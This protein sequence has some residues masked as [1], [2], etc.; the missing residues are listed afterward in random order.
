MFI[1]PWLQSLKSRWFSKSKTVKRLGKRAAEKN[2]VP[3]TSES[4]EPRIVL[5]AFDLVTVIPN[6]GLFLND[7]A[8]MHEAPQELTLRFSPGQTIDPA[9]VSAG[10][11]VTR[12]GLDGAFGTSDDVT[13]TPGYIGVGES[14]NEIIVRFAQT[15]PDDQ[16][17]IK[18]DGTG[19]DSLRNTLGENFN[20]GVDEQFNF[21]LDLGAFVEAVVPQPVLRAQVVTINNAVQVLDGDT[22]TI[23]HGSQT[24][25][26]EFNRTG[27]IQANRT[28]VNISGAVTTTDIAI[29]L[30]NA[31]NTYS[32]LTPAFGAN[33]TQA[34][35]QVTV[36]GTAFDPVVTR[37]AS[38]PA[39]TTV[40]AGG[41]TQATDTIVVY[42]NHDTLELTS[43][44]TPG[45]Y[46]LTNSATGE[47]ILPASVTY[48]PTL[49]T[50]VLR[51]SSTL[52]TASEFNLKIGTSPEGSTTAT[53]ATATR[54]G[55]V[56]G[57]QFFATTNYIGDI[58][59]SSTALN[60]FDLY[61][62]NL[63]LNGDMQIVVDTSLGLDT[64]VRIFNS[65][66]VD[67]TGTAVANINGGSG[68][69]DA[70]LLTGQI[71]GDYYVGISSSGNAA[72]DPAAGTG[73][74]NGTGGYGSY[75]FQI[76]AS[77][78]I[79]TADNGSTN[80]SSFTN[81][82]N[83]GQLG[84]SGFTFNGAISPQTWIEMPPLAGG[85]DEPGHR[86]L[87]PGQFSGAEVGHGVGGGTDPV[88]PGAIGTI[89]YSF[90][91]TFGPYVNVMTDAQKERAREIFEIYAWYTGME[92]AE[93]QSGGIAVVTGDPRFLAP[94]LPPSSGVSIANSSIAIMNSSINWND[95]FG[96]SWMGTAFHEIGHSIG[97]GHSYDVPSTQGGAED[98][99]VSTSQTEPYFTMEADFV[100]LLRMYR[101]D[102]SDID[103][104]RFELD[105]P[106]RLAAE[107]IAERDNSRLNSNLILYREQTIG[108]QTVRTI[109]AQND[110]YYSNDS[111]LDLELEAG[112]YFIG[113]SASGNDKYDPD[114]SDSGQ[115]GTTDGAYQLKVNFKPSTVASSLVDATGRPVDG[116]YDGKS[117]GAH[118]FWFTTG[119]ITA[120]VDKT[121]T[122]VSDGSLAAPFKQIDEALNAAGF[123]GP[124]T[125]VRI[126]GNGGSDN[127]TTT[128]SNNTPYLIGLDFNGVP[129]ADS[130]GFSSTGAV[131]ANVRPGEFQIPQGVTVMVESGALLKLHSAVI[132][133]GTSDLGIDRS[134][135]AFQV[136]GTPLQ[137]VH[138]TSL[139]D[140]SQGGDS[141]GQNGLPQVADWGGIVFRGD[142]DSA[143]TGVTLNYVNHANIK[144]GGGQVEVES[145]LTSFDAIHIIDTRPTVSFNTITN[146]SR[147]PISASPNAFDDDGFSIT[148][149]N[150][151]NP[152]DRRIG[153]DVHGNTVLNNS[154]NG[155]FVRIDTEFGT[156]VTQLDLSGRFDDT[157]ITHIITE[158]LFI[159]GNAGGP[160]MAS[161]GGA[162]VDLRMSGRL[163]ID[164]GI[165]VKVGKA[166]IEATAGAANV[167]AEGT[168]ANPIRFTSLLDDQYGNGGTFDASNN[169]TS[170]PSTQNY[171]GGFVFN[172]TS[173]GSFDYVSMTY[174]GGSGI[175]NAEGSFSA[176]SPITVMQGRLRVANSDFHS[177]EGGATGSVI[178]VLGSQPVIVGNE[179]SNN[180]AAIININ[181][182]SLKDV[183]LPD[184]GRSTGYRSIGS[185]YVVDVAQ[186]TS[187]RFDD[188]LQTFPDNRGPLIRLNTYV[189]NTT[190]GME[191]RGEY[192]TV[193]G[194]WDDTDI[195]HIVRSEITVPEHHTYSGL[196]LQS[197]D[198]GSLVVK[199]AGANA[200]FSA[201]G[202]PLDIDDR[203]GGSIY[204]LGRPG[205]PVVMTSLHDDT[206]GAGFMPNGFP[207]LDTNGNGSATTPTPG[208][209][210]SIQLRQYSNDRN[211]ATVLEQEPA[212]TH[213]NDVNNTSLR[214]QFLGTLAPNENSGDENRRLGFEVHGEISRDASSD[215]DVYSFSATVGTE[216]W[217]DIDQ[218]TYALD[219]MVELLN[220]SGVVLARA[221]N[222]VTGDTA[223]TSLIEYP[224]NKFDWLGG[225]FYTSNY[226]DAGM[227]V[228][229]PG[230]A[231]QTGTYY[232]RVRS[233]PV[234]GEEA[235]P[236]AV[237]QGLTAGAYQMQIRLRQVDEKPGS[238]VRNTDLRY[239]SNA[240]EVIGMPAHS[241]LLGEAGESSADNN[242]FGGAQPIG[243]L[244][245]SDRNTISVSGTLSGANDVDFYSFTLD[246]EQ[247]QVIGGLSDG[248]KSWATVFDIDY[249]DG[250]G[251]ADTVMAV[252]NAQGQL[253]WIGRDSDVED[254]QA[255]P[256]Q[257]NDY[258]DLLRGSVGK[259]DA[260]IGSVQLTAGAGMTSADSA[261]NVQTP[262]GS[263]TTYYVAVASNGR[264][265]TVLNATF[266]SAATAPLVRLEPVNSV[267]RI[268]EDHIGFT[269][270]N[271]NGADIAPDTAGPLIDIGTSISLSTHIRPFTL[272]DVALYV[273]TYNTLN[274]V[275]PYRGSY[276][277]LVSNLA[278]GYGDLDM[279][280]DGRLWGYRSNINGGATEGFITELD[281][282]MGTIQG[283]L[284]DNIPVP[285]PDAP[286]V[287]QNQSN[288][289]DA[290]A[291][292][293]TD[294]AQFAGDNALYLSVRDDGSGES[295]LYRA[296]DNGDASAADNTPYGYM[297]NITGG[298][299]TGATTGMQFVNGVLYGVSTGGQFFT[300]NTGNGA[301]TLIADLS[302][303]VTNFAGLTDA[304]QN[305]EGG[306]YANFLFAINSSGRMV[307]IDPTTGALQ[308]I[309]DNNRDGTV[310][311]NFLNTSIGGVT[312]LAF[313]PIDFNLW[314]PTMQRSGDQGHGVN[315]APDGTRSNFDVNING[316]DSSQASGGASM[317]F[318]LEEWVDNPIGNYF[319]YEGVNGTANGQYGVQGALGGT[320][321][322]INTQRELTASALAIGNNVN[323]PGGAY[324][325][326]TTNSFSL[327][328]FRD[329][330]KPTLYFNYLLGTQ[331]ANSNSD[332]M[333]DSARVFVSADNGV[334][335]SLVATN[336]SVLSSTSSED[337]EL[338]SFLSTSTTADT[339]AS[340]QRVQELFDN[341]ATWRQARIDLADFVGEAS[342]M[343]R[344]DYSTSGVSGDRNSAEYSATEGDQYGNTQTDNSGRARNNNVL[345]F[346]VDDIIVG[347]AERGEMVT[348]PLG[349]ASTES[350]FFGVPQN[351]DSSDPAEQ[352]SGRYQLEI[353]RGEQYSA[354]PS[355]TE[356]GQTIGTTFDTN[357]R[358]VAGQ[359]IFLGE[360]MTDGDLITIDS[361]FR[362]ITFEFDLNNS[363]NGGLNADTAGAY[364]RVN[365]QGLTTVGQRATALAAA[366]NA[367]A[368]AT[369]Q[370]FRVQAIPYSPGTNSP[371]V[372]LVNAASVT[373]TVSPTAITQ[374]YVDENNDGPGISIPFV[375]N[376]P[377]FNSGINT[378][379][380][381]LFQLFGAIGSS[382]ADVP[383]YPDQDVDFIQFTMT[384]GERIIVDLEVLGLLPGSPLDV[385]PA[386]VLALIRDDGG[387]S[388][389]FEVFSFG[390]GITSFPSIDYFA[391]V[392]GTY[393][394]A[395]LGDDGDLL[396]PPIN[397]DISF[398][399]SPIPLATMGNAQ[400]DYVLNIIA[401]DPPTILEVENYARRGD[402]NLQRQQGQVIIESNLIRDSAQYGIQV[403][404]GD[405]TVG[406]D[407]AHPGSPRF[408]ASVSSQFFVTGVY[409]TNNV[410]ANSGTGGILLAG[411]STAGGIDPAAQ[412]FYKVINNTIYGGANPSGIGINITGNAAPTLLN[413]IIANTAVGIQ[414][415]TGNTVVGHTLFSNVANPG[416]LG[417]N[418]TRINTPG[419]AT[420]PLFVNPAVYNFYLAQGS[421][422][423]DV[424]L[425]TL[426]DRSSYTTHTNP[427]GIPLSPLFAPNYDLYGQL[428]VADQTPGGPGGGGGSNPFKDLGGVERA[429]FAGGVAR[430][431]N[432]EDN[433]GNGLDYDPTLTL[434]H[435]DYNDA[436]L[437]QFVVELVD[438]GIGIDDTTV[439]SSGFTLRQRT[440]N[441]AGY[442]D[443]VDGEDYLWTY[444][445]N[446]NQVFFTSVSTFPLDARYEIVV[447]RQSIL[448]F[449]G[450]V[451]QAN[452]PTGSA[453][454]L[455]F[456][457]VVTDGAN[458]AP[459]LTA[460]TAAV[461]NEDVDLVFSV[462]NGNAI[463]VADPDAFLGNDRLRVM[464]SAS[465]GTINIPSGPLAALTIHNGANGSGLIVVSGTIAE[466]NAALNGL[467]FRNDLDEPVLPPSELV[468]LQVAVSDDDDGDGDGNYGPPP[469]PAASAI[470]M[471]AITVNA[472]NDAPTLNALSN[473]IVDEDSG[474]VPTINLAG[475]TAGG[476]ETQNLTVTA[477]SN[478]SALIPGITVGYTPNGTTGT[479]DFTPAPNQ[480]G[481]ATVTVTVRDAGFD[482][483]AGNGDDGIFTRT[484]TVTVNPVN[485]APTITAPVTQTVNEDAGVQQLLLDNVTA[486]P[487]ESQTLTFT[488]VSNMPGLIP[489]P[490]VAYTQGNPTALLSYTPV[491]NQFGTA[492]ITL[493]VTD[494]GTGLN[495]TVYTFD[496]VVN[497]VNDAPTLAAFGTAAYTIDEDA[498]ATVV[499]LSGIGVGPA[500]ESSQNIV[501]V[502]A[503][504]NN[505]TLFPNAG[506]L[507]N[508][509]PNNSTGTLTFQ[510]AANIYG[511]ATITVTV[512]DDGGT[513]NGGVN[514]F[515]RT[516]TVTVNP[517]NDPP[518]IDPI[519]NQIINEDAGLTNLGLTGIAAGP[520]GESAQTVLI[521]A[522]SDNQTLIPN[523]TI[524]YTAGNTTGTLTYTPVANRSGVA[525]ITVTL[526][527]NGGGVN[528]IWQEVFTITV[529]ALNDAPTL[530][531]IPSPAP[532]LED[533]ALQTINLSGITAGPLETQGLTITATSD[534]PGLIPN[535]TVNY[536]SPNGTG[537]LTYTPVANQSGTA[538]ITVRV[539]DSG[540]HDGTTNFNFIERTFV[541]TVTAVN[542]APTLDPIGDLSIP[543]DSALQTINLSGISAG[544]LETQNLTVTASSNRPDLTGLISV[545]Y[546]PNDPTGSLSFTP[547]GNA[548]GTATITV[549]VTD[550]GGIANGGVN[551]FSRTFTVELTPVEDAP[552]DLNLN[553]T[554]VN[555]NRPVGSVVGIF[556]PTDLDPVD[557][558]T[559]TLVAGFGDNDNASFQIVN[560]ELR[561]N[562]IFDF[563]TKSVYTI[564][565]RVT[566]SFNLWTEK[567]FTITIN[568]VNDAPTLDPLSNLNLAEDALLQTV[569][570]FGITDG[571]DTAVQNLSVTATSSHP[572]I[573]PHP[574]VNY[575]PNGT[576]GSI[577]FT[578][579]GNANG[580]VTIT[581]T[582]TDN[583][584]TANGGLNTFSRTFTVNISP[585]HDAPTDISLAP[586]TVLE[587]SPSG[588]L[589]GQLTSTDPDFGNTFAYSLVS[590]LG[591]TDNSKFQIINDQ[592][593]ATGAIDFEGQPTYS[594]RVRTLDNG[595]LSYEKVLTVNALDVNEP[596]TNIVLTPN[597]VNE[598]SPINTVVGTLS[599]IDPDV[600]DSQTYA[601]VSGAGATDNALFAL[602]GNTIRT[603]AVFDR[604]VKSSY[605]IRILATD[606]QGHTIERALTITIGNVNETPTDI[607]LSNNMVAENSAVG[608]V[609]GNLSTS[610]IDSGDSFT[611]TLVSGLGS[612]DNG[613]F[614]IVGGQLQ[615]AGNI[616][617]EAKSLLSVRVRSMDVGGL[618]VEK[619]FSIGVVNINETPT[620]LTLTNNVVDENRPAN[621]FVGNLNVSDEDA[622][623]TFTYQLVGGIGSDDNASFLL[624][625]NQLR[626][627][628]VFDF[629][630][631]SS[632]TIRVRVTDSAS[633]S[634]EQVFTITINNTNDP[635]VVVL[636][637]ASGST[638]GKKPVQVDPL[639]NF[640][641]TDS[642][643]LAGGKLIVKIAQ[644]EQTG[645]ELTVQKDKHDDSGLVL[646][647]AKGKSVL[648]LGKLVIATVT[649]G[650][651]GIPLEINFLAGATQDIVRRVMQNVTFRG[652]PYPAPRT[653]SMQLIDD[654]QLESN[655][656]TRQ[657]TVN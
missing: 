53:L 510:P 409:L 586:N 515:T 255:A 485:D 297:G 54:V 192:L 323:V 530:N 338:P 6:Q 575:T 211:V 393:Y 115:G 486:G 59:T 47:I 539:T 239:S 43:A 503:T 299:I 206:V 197:S 430:M 199:L 109:V 262:A 398:P 183:N 89:Y 7:G 215:V 572:S 527:D 537:T 325:S 214:A 88:A 499:N 81:S 270:Y 238:T 198:T 495:S 121:F 295:R 266:Q 25:V 248:G 501:S 57:D 626:T 498:A 579:V 106:G 15:L 158:N 336:N 33:A 315:I 346:Y 609:V 144:F 640:T 545:T 349:Q 431:F 360:T 497:P 182:N 143:T 334:T 555:E 512:T 337:A 548:N 138:L 186:S 29:A 98:G 384:A 648:K 329:T 78:F 301:A 646:K 185:G 638:T 202:D 487:F 573:I 610:D 123:A 482:G 368:T 522:I 153:P 570:L 491:L 521:S 551:T 436:L 371:R 450:N 448:D 9:S 633:N 65:A 330:D 616:N 656:A 400:F 170:T 204:V 411:D 155:L 608:T 460:P 496:I 600:G 574:T 435:V 112:T 333:F 457:I 377:A 415:A 296:R 365:I 75:T 45:Y 526:Q 422:A 233:Q 164:P 151:I 335:W 101:N 352:L 535:P 635:P 307:A 51:F 437:T 83:L 509:T 96:G 52:P 306:A 20:G 599:A 254:D 184:Y 36:T 68:G 596:Q 176:Y 133:V 565:V 26:F 154:L 401:G 76:Q 644:G 443:L 643:S 419:F 532:I 260:Y 619:V 309:F 147:A 293:R 269:G 406:S 538:T 428:R 402:S 447:D 356:P 226:M 513:A 452:Q 451:L 172:H 21:E 632:Y 203:I 230:T 505:Q 263:R 122:G 473:V 13:V 116:D 389:S 463:R 477:N 316:R 601:F 589:V 494:S 190:N 71:A 161:P 395:V 35:G 449:A 634:I 597:S 125:V 446:T 524:T 257:G 637:S 72:Y 461:V 74:V 534:V 162:V 253:L 366:I 374:M 124:G 56:F 142:S 332:Q 195:V 593:F 28:E 326:L 193:A 620:A 391:T 273:S 359:T 134:A 201:T 135:G 380:P 27:G 421:P 271:S 129:L 462:A 179:F 590:G 146:N 407:A 345:G 467:R 531:V 454:E 104:Y 145:V 627:G 511:S 288:N 603:Q 10:I 650:E 32:G 481:S 327:E 628:V 167:I 8:I 317:Y 205:F 339:A 302:A 42:F 533:A 298:G 403:R 286:T 432:P 344:F 318:G 290:L 654:T 523:P 105:Q 370:T 580:M 169:G 480:F 2:G 284:P 623:D 363:W 159:T 585:E 328:T 249:A 459:V 217:I 639:A 246:F 561:T 652:K 66:G 631:K 582:V 22:I 119:T 102:S 396:T 343:L 250:I 90:P 617:F 622:G 4:L 41:L 547:V 222:N 433:D 536:T 210:R 444:N 80:N 31:I 228:I 357:D 209:W 136:L 221:T 348:Y 645:D 549:T 303:T 108:G 11:Q 289:V 614:Q 140:D 251:R 564:R 213:G 350:S 191:V 314:H 569:N 420:A 148:G 86:Q 347:F 264:L 234:A 379:A 5:A 560:D 471:I 194:V 390:D 232:V 425:N 340:N 504:S 488:A 166:R 308:T 423:I 321:Q 613:L 382:G 114:I 118:N 168:P 583:G 440:V 242:A 219:T 507:V 621:T 604:E 280:S 629:E 227:R 367:A 602:S 518:L 458:D 152:F 131:L 150:Y 79:P 279:R 465:A 283:A 241:P 216:I 520:F 517:I 592:L 653:I 612:T 558:F 48:N 99:S 67:I 19:V 426:A 1:T 305:V 541:V 268:V 414:G 187:L 180:N 624:N 358:L 113:V 97:L 243:A 544:P 267:R 188:T 442:V 455:K 502:V 174:A 313:S 63:P 94:Q 607:G 386:S 44:Q 605:S 225:D 212:L 529:N 439:L 381:G 416:T 181:V 218:T 571:G 173:T 320:S 50:A 278:D 466:L 85:P 244:L 39:S 576:T 383:D 319:T 256:G 275:D 61:R 23:R 24:R 235:N 351:P 82:T 369:G 550:N 207:M 438:A 372:D 553:S 70:V 364:Y 557:T 642:A 69:M 300:I 132:D 543:E 157:D 60:D 272:E 87:P 58:G 62:F 387:F 236:A 237:T 594:I 554:V 362:T 156:A 378:G 353:R 478:N 92:V 412:A 322:N 77:P 453:D 484:F 615:V 282:G 354:P 598:N 464:L 591:G 311:S 276:E 46:R 342:L 636:P 149:L 223:G 64:A 568:E 587:N 385:P 584:G 103:M 563:E 16:Y 405:R 410:I 552:T 470:Q 100:H 361:G 376:A 546:S 171:W 408:L 40:A 417:S 220:S 625:G 476:G 281:T 434:I 441:D 489:N 224:L 606:S 373:A 95:D 139:R 287:H 18:V 397:P 141:D 468:F 17:R 519:A 200:G 128:F 528:N 649:G 427:L 647:L 312:G 245:V 418:S 163:A 355:P 84:T 331:N 178:Y 252:F 137:E 247:V 111:F 165:V 310:D 240:I 630:T 657:I 375:L 490:T 394:L 110:D 274:V 542:D 500:N 556:T 294:V 38:I 261:G 231:G 189:G 479:L 493:T 37:L 196:R 265:P 177:N 429:D 578:P 456:T 559:Y 3:A 49:N 126:V 30:A 392:T 641:D 34:S 229:L 117:D 588:T 581:V 472:V 483:I 655:I 567:Q 595:G 258:D 91:A 291:W 93:V 651:R 516:F 562:E 469:S 160:L 304:P 285:N 424:S 107:T 175:P 540:T 514:T 399:P 259:L 388:Y 73:A 14:T 127:D 292:R 404:P 475:I 566:D 474:A 508:Y 324:G 277:Y 130:D 611:Y 618:T 577:S 413:N 445:P 120:F 55:S 341:T 506:L 12:A 492:T 208:D 525:T